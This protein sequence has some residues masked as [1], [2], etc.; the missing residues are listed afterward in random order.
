M[1]WTELFVYTSLPLLSSLNPL[2]TSSDEDLLQQVLQEVPPIPD[3][4]AGSS[5]VI[6]INLVNKW[7]DTHGTYVGGWGG[8]GWNWGPRMGVRIVVV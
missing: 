4:V 6:R 2:Q 1:D 8:D 3:E 7:L 5:S